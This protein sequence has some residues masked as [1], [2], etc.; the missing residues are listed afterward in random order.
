MKTTVE[1]TTGNHY[2]VFI[3][4]EPVSLIKYPTQNSYLKP[5][6]LQELAEHEANRIIKAETN[7]K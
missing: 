4:G 6:S 5:L 3:D 7:K 1:H 2:Q